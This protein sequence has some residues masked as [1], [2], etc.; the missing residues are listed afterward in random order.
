MQ[1]E[2]TRG[3]DLF[4]D[5]GTLAQTGWARQLIMYY[6]REKMRASMLRLKEWDCYCILNPEFQLNLIVADVGYF[7][8]AHVNWLDYK[9]GK[10]KSSMAVKL[11]TR[12]NLHLPATADTGDVEFSKG[13]SWIRF[14][15][16]PGEVSQRELTFNFPGYVFEGRKGISGR[17]AL[18]R[19]PKGDTMVNVIPF[20]DPRHFVYV[21]KIVCMPAVGT[22]ELGGGS[23]EFKGEENN[24]YAALDWS[25]G[26]FPYRTQWWWSFASGAVN[27]KPF[28]FNIDYGFGTESSKSMLFYDG[29]GHHLGEV[30]YSF[31]EKDPRKLWRF[32]SSDGRVALQLEPV[33]SNEEDMNLLVLRTQGTHAYGFITG[34]VVLDDGTKLSIERNHRV[35]G[36]AEYCTHRW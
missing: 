35:F 20:K 32:S 36:S 6:N 24:S 23:Y 11:L 2:I 8:M 22:V 12:G 25:R 34:E 1:E 17:V 14:K 21:Q 33:Y 28:G 19:D 31:D 7:G 26:V 3:S 27:G 15:H 16:I 18:T 10:D 9:A 4:D 13:G 5:R 29:K 30:A